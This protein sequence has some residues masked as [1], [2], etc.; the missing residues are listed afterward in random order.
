MKVGQTKMPLGMLQLNLDLAVFLNKFSLNCCKPLI[1]RV[2]VMLIL[3]IFAFC[4]V[5]NFQRCL[6]CPS[7]TENFDLIA[8]CLSPPTPTLTHLSSF[9]DYLLTA[10]KKTVF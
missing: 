8:Y 10:D 4:G 6:V 2:L 5:V 7:R 9:Q 3:T 1:C